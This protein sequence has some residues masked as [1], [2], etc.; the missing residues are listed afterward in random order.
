MK[1]QLPATCRDCSPQERREFL[2]IAAL[3]SIAAISGT[4]PAAPA[5]A[6]ELAPRP[7]LAGPA[8]DFARELFATL[9]G[10]QKKTILLPWDH[11]TQNGRGYPT[12]LKMFNSPLNQPLGKL[13]KAPQIELVERT[14]KALARDDEGYRQFTRGG[15][16]DASKSFG[17]CGVNFFGNP[18]DPKEK[19]AFLFTGHHFTLRCDGDA[20]DSTAFGGPIY[21]GHTPHGYSHKNI[22]FYQTRQV[23]S[24]YDMLDGKQ[25]ER[26]VAA[27]DPGEL[28][29]SVKLHPESKTRPGIAFAELSKDQQA[30]V[31]QVMRAVLSPYRTQDV[32]EVMRIIEVTGG[33]DAIHLAFY[34]DED[35]IDNSSPWSFWRLEGP[36]FVWNYRVLPHVHTYVQIA[37]V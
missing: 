16:W 30:Q 31:K 33:M 17:N 9:D 11:G 28:E 2:R 25:R 12:R 3:G 23:L 35:S 13:L 21:Y 6:E 24:V 27:G 36:G 20:N 34:K 19:F 18:A 32:D 15:T 10:D 14:L 7:R 22:F 26:A 1:S 4:L 5:Q 29:P 8:E 37:R